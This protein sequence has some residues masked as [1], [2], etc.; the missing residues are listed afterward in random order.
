ML[1]MQWHLLF[2]QFQ[3][4]FARR[5]VWHFDWGKVESQAMSPPRSS[6]RPAKVV[7]VQTSKDFEKYTP[8][9]PSSL[10]WLAGKITVFNRR[11]H[12]GNGWFSIDMLVLGGVFWMIHMCFF[13]F[14]TSCQKKSTHQKQDTV[15]TTFGE[16]VYREQKTSWLQLN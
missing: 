11:W 9:S 1:L 7:K 12:L 16:Q 10:T 5:F 13:H 14:A 8:E 2:H 6:G 15:T 3:V 4:L